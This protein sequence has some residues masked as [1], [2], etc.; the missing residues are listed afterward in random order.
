MCETECDE[1]AASG[2]LFPARSRVRALARRDV[3]EALDE[4]RVVRSKNAALLE[5]LPSLASPFRGLE[6]QLG[7]LV[8]HGFNER[9]ALGV[10]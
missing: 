4:P 7:H 5:K 8:E 2:C 10:G 9:P 1:K 6:A 3:E